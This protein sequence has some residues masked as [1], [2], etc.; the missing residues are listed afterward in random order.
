MTHW[1][2]KYLTLNHVSG[3][4]DC[5]DLVKR[6]LLDE[7]GHVV[8]LP[9]ERQWRRWTPDRLVDTVSGQFEETLS[10]QEFDVVLMGYQGR[11]QS[12][13]CHV[14]VFAHCA[15]QDW[16][17]HTMQHSGTVFGRVV[18]LGVYALKIQGHFRWRD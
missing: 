13:G 9:S 6:V 10:P 18:D 11:E 14:G 12:L 5:S 17:L 3:E 8:D 7:Q 4:F 16:V 2:Q 1:S 15:G